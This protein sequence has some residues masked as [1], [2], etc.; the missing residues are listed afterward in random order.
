VRRALAVGLLVAG[1]LLA[2]VVGAGPALAHAT[3]VA[4]D[5]ADGSRLGD[6]PEQV[7]VTFS[8]HVTFSSGY[9]RVVDSKGRRVD[10]GSVEHPGGD[11]S[12][13]SVHL[14]QGW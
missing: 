3:V 6:P 2:A 1:W 9:L 8:E 14:R 10:T 4:T 13:V 7:S 5:P 11:S 12:T